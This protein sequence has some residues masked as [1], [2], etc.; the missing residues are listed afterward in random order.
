MNQ[1]FM[2]E[3]LA[4]ARL[5][6]KEGEAPVGAVVVKAGRIVGRGRNRR[7]RDKNPLGHAE[8]EA[9]YEASRV[10]GGWR[11]SGC[12]LYVTL[13]PCPMCAGAAV[14]ARVDRVVFGAYDPKAGSVD[15]VVSLFSLPCSIFSSQQP[16]GV[17]S[18]TSAKTCCQSVFCL[19]RFSA[20]FKRWLICSLNAAASS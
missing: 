5:A 3:A 6:A 8:L 15:S 20:S 13:E 10:L 14:N 12:E 16:V 9:L 7:E 18:A 4:L 1:A 17:L 2:E 11:L 19:R